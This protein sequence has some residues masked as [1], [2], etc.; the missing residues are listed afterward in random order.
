[1]STSFTTTSCN[2]GP[3]YGSINNQS[4]ASIIACLKKT[5]TLEQ[6]HLYL[7]GTGIV[8]DLSNYNP[9]INIDTRD[10]RQI[11][12]DVLPLRL[13][14]TTLELDFNLITTNETD[15]NKDHILGTA[16]INPGDTLGINLTK[17]ITAGSMAIDPARQF[18]NVSL[19]QAEIS[20]GLLF[21]YNSK[22]PAGSNNNMTFMMAPIN[23]NTTGVATQ[24]LGIYSANS[25]GLLK[26]VALFQSAQ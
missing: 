8:M 12:N 6:R 20:G 26:L 25:T 15:K 18:T 5:L 14:G 9:L 11:G 1:M 17:M 21:G 10:I 22:T 24:G 4:F 3:G 13:N 7:G 19:G 23:T 2:P 16:V